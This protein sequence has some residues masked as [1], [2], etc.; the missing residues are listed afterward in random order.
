MN[1]CIHNFNT[2]KGKYAFLKIHFYLFGVE[3]KC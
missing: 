2:D 1:E 3:K